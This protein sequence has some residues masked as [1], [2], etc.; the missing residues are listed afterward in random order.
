MH[1]LGVRG[2]RHTVHGINAARHTV[3][4]S[5]GRGCGC[6]SLLM[7]AIATGHRS[8]STPNPT[9]GG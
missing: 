1:V 6:A 7:A 3:A 2:K 5:P 9:L 8:S 4:A